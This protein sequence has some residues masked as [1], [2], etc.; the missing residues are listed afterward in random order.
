MTAGNSWHRY[1]SSLRSNSAPKDLMASFSVLDMV[2]L[3]GGGV[4]FLTALGGLRA[5]VFAMANV[6]V[7]RRSRWIVNCGR[8]TF[9]QR[10]LLKMDRL[11][12]LRTVLTRGSK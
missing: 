9:L 12:K 2:G 4:P 11:R 3:A 10:L 1:S 7:N 5:P 8:P 6:L